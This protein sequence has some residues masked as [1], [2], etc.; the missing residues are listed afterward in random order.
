ML[1]GYRSS[2]VLLGRVPWETA[3][4][5]PW[6]SRSDP[7][8]ASWPWYRKRLFSLWHHMEVDCSPKTAKKFWLPS[9]RTAGG[10]GGLISWHSHRSFSWEGTWH[11]FAVFP[12]QRQQRTKGPCCAHWGTPAAK[13]KFHEKS[14]FIGPERERE[15]GGGGGLTLEYKVL[16]QL[17]HNP[18]LKIQYFSPYS[19]ITP[20]LLGKLIEEI[21]FE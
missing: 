15:R 18:Q 1:V 10:G 21:V 3:W 8:S 6:H 14:T 9:R 12:M 19:W 20:G 13:C 16:T 11:G 7:G 2:V 4:P 17:H 5:W